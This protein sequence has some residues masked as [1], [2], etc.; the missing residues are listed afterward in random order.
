MKNKL[1]NLINKFEELD[2]LAKES[3]DLILK[4]QES[5]DKKIT[6]KRDGK[7]I[8]ITEKDL[9]DEIY[10]QADTDA[11]IILEN[12]YP[13]AFKK[14]KEFNSKGDELVKFLAVDF[15]LPTKKENLVSFGKLIKFI[16]LMINEYG[17]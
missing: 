17:K 16:R 1:E 6:I 12:I 7:N 10:Y 5:K 4:A 13:D 8:D 2:L 9:W 11:S 3:S 14:S 15:D